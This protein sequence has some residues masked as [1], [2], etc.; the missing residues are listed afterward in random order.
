MDLTSN[1]SSDK[2]YS[3]QQRVLNTCDHSQTLKNW[4]KVEVKIKA[5]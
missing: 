1:F 2:F 5:G 3:D 4:S